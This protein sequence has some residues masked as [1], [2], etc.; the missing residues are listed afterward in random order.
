MAANEI[1]ALDPQAVREPPTSF[2]RSFRMIG[3]SL[4]LTACVVGSGEL[5]MTTTLGAKAGFVCLWV[6]LVS[7]L[8]KVAV[9]LEFGKQAICSG[10]TSLESFSTLPGPR[11]RGAGWAVW[12]WLVAR[13]AQYIQYGGIVGGVALTMHIAVPSVDVWIWAWIAGISAGLLVYRGHYRF[14]EKFAVALTAMFSVFTVLCVLFLQ[15]TPYRL[16]LAD[17]ASGLSFHLPL[18]AIGV[19]IAAFGATGVSADEIMSYS[20]WCIEKGYARW[21]GPRDDS[22]AWGRRARGWIRVMYM[23]GVVSMLIYTFATA[24][25]YVLGAAILHDRGTIPQGYETISTL[26]NIYTES[27]GP[28]AMV[29]FLVASVVVLFS[30]MFVNNAA[31]S[32]MIS[33]G[34]AQLR[35]LDYHNA[36]QRQRWIATLAFLSPITWTILFLTVRAPVAMIVA[37]GIGVAVLLLVV[38]YAA[39]IFRY[40]RLDPR[41]RPGRFYD[42]M[43][44]LSFIAIVSVGIK[45]AAELLF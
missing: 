3:P 12:L 16:T 18:A 10:T 37:G 31:M 20:Y 27:F 7:C 25:F 2:L 42:V 44:W 29:I 13:A 35:F 11:W 26:S 8:L 22:E 15:S 38:V 32:R 40:R 6:I 33:D 21:T 23:D 5:I 14:I 24:A 43:L 30:T 36:R 19:A 1:Y 9:Q 4:V 39:W 41:L 17:L 45:I 28:E 34:F